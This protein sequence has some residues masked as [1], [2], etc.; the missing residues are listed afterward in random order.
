M[1]PI[2]LSLALTMILSVWACSD[3]SPDPT[4]IQGPTSA[5]LSV[6]NNTPA[7]VGLDKKF[8]DLT[9][10]FPGFAGYFYEAP[11]KL[12][13]LST[14]PGNNE[15]GLRSAVRGK[16]G[17]PRS[18]ALENIRFESASYDF[19]ELS[20]WRAQLDQAI[21]VGTL[22]FSDIDEREN[23]VS[24][25]V[26]S[27]T[28]IATVSSLA[29][30]LGIPR[31]AV[32]IRTAI[33]PTPVT[34]LTQYHRPMVGALGIATDQKQC[35]AGFVAILASQNVMI[36]NGHCTDTFGGVEDTP[37]YQPF[38]DTGNFVGYEVADRLF[39]SNLQD[40]C[41][42]GLVCRYSDSAAF[43]LDSTWDS[44]GYIAKTNSAGSGS[45]EIT[46]Y[47][48]IVGEVSEPTLGETLHKIGRSSG[49]T[50][51]DVDRTCVHFDIGND[52]RL[53]CQ[54]TVDSSDGGV[55]AGD[56]GSP[57]FSDFGLGEIYL[58]GIVWGG[59]S[60]DW[61]F[62]AMTNIEGD[63][64][65]MTTEAPSGGGGCSPQISC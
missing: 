48:K 11:G 10:T 5:T 9:R 8:E 56:S 7:Q 44:L 45:I 15:G 2:K 21:S 42:S 30:Q 40:A 29:D 49:W 50:S 47:F 28:A 17:S 20:R 41:K 14:R 46:G 19:S 61:V 38:S 43:E 18:N 57:V 51:G 55:T 53:I 36:T 63:L 62:S 52:R 54:D 34:S 32:E 39:I 59:G 25:G 27:V 1:R 24:L 31:D 37:F 12:V 26:V 64:G 13:V 58:Y 16:L 22:I 4:S 65:T 33:Q 3:S 6:A 35:S 23:R 60:L